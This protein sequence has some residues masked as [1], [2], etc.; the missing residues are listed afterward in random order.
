MI[1]IVLLVT[2]FFFACG[3]G[4]KQQPVFACNMNALSAEERKQLSAEIAPKL[5]SSKHVSREL[6]DGFEIQF[7]SGRE[8]LPVVTQWLSMEGR[9]CPFFNL[10]MSIKGN[11]GPLTVR[12]TGENGIKAFIA[13]ELPGIAK[14]TGAKKSH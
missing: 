8:M 14:L 1:T 6:K 11:G 5:K 13:G 12:I 2:P 7:L 4:K 3:Q 9:C 10:S